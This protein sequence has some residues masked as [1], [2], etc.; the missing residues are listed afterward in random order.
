MYEHTCGPPWGRASHCEVEAL[1]SVGGLMSWSQRVQRVGYPTRHPLAGSVSTR[2][3]PGHMGAGS[4][5]AAP[6]S[7]PARL[8]LRETRRVQRIAHSM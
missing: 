2:Q 8:Q 5:S 7:G 1:V 4:C 3:H 6:L